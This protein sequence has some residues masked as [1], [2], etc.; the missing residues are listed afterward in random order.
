MV[1]PFK[2]FCVL[3]VFSYFLSWNLIHPLFQILFKQQRP[4]EEKFIPHEGLIAALSNKKTS[5]S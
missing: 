2:K 3:N 1:P 4:P 5:P